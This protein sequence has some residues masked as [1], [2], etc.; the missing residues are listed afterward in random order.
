[1]RPYIIDLL[2]HYE[3]GEHACTDSMI[4]DVPRMN[5]IFHN[6]ILK[7]NQFVPELFPFPEVEIVKTGQ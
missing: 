7:I 4:I 3:D 1:M 2:S 6:N 5:S